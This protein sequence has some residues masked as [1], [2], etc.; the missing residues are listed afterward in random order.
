[1]TVAAD[2]S[3][4]YTPYA[5]LAATGGTDSFLVKVSD[6]PGNPFHIHG[7]ALF[8]GDAYQK[9]TVDLAATTATSPLGTQDQIDAE[10][11]ATEI[12]NTPIMA[13]AKWL[14]KMSWQASAEKLFGTIDAKNM[15]LLDK[16]VDEYA[17]QAALELQLL[18][19]ND[20]HVIQQVMPPH[21]WFNEAF[22]GARSSTTTPTRSTG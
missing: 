9:V 7:L 8:F 19:P 16:A 13:L 21:T 5:E 14:L 3:F 20:S 22:G 11:L 6:Y 2:G 10:K 1:V 17:L 18:N 12:A 4:T 15:A